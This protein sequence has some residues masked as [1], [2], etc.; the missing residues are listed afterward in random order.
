MI[1]LPQKG[2]KSCILAP[3][4][5]WEPVGSLTL[6]ELVSY[7]KIDIKMDS[8]S[9]EYVEK[10]ANSEIF[11]KMPFHTHYR[12]WKC[13][14][15]ISWQG[16]L[17]TYQKNTFFERA[18]GDIQNHFTKKNN[19]IETFIYSRE[20]GVSFIENNPISKTGHA[21]ALW[22]HPPFYSGRRK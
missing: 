18:I 9:S 2:P 22:N 21:R 3:R 14:G 10:G 17:P 20:P 16:S 11:C 5:V 7:W 4:T 12:T 1:P 6:F 8:E 19:K 13:F 15:V